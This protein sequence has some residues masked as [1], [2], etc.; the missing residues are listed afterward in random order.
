MII[1]IA[2]MN[3]LVKPDTRQEDKINWFREVSPIFLRGDVCN[4]IPF[5]SSVLHMRLIRLSNI[6]FKAV[7]PN[8]SSCIG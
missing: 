6:A 1:Q 4:A 2:G 8:E 5:Q 3:T 7:H